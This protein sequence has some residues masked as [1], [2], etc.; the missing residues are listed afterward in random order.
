M[1]PAGFEPA[2]N[3]LKV[4]C[5]TVELRAPRAHWARPATTRRR[6]NGRP[7]SR[8]HRLL[9]GYRTASRLTLHDSP[10]C[11]APHTATTLGDRSC[12]VREP[13][14]EACRDAARVLD[15]ASQN[16][17]LAG[18]AALQETS[19]PI[20]HPPPHSGRGWRGGAAEARPPRHLV[21]ARMTLAA[22]PPRHGT[23]CPS[24]RSPGAGRPGT[25]PR[26]APRPR[27]VPA[28]RAPGRYP[29]SPNNRRASR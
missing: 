11:R 28:R 6:D 13:R 16:A 21:T 5:S 26:L 29:S 8:Q 25:R 22:V 20:A 15:T 23:T 19:R 9:V 27:T 7:L 3:G 1:R 10:R 2:T 12:S 14:M 18:V 4:R 17:L 24:P